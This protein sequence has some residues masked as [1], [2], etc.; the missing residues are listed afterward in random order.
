[1]GNAESISQNAVNMM[2]HVP[3]HR[4][5][6]TLEVDLIEEI[7]RIHG[8]DQLVGRGGYRVP[9]GAVRRPRDVAKERLRGWLSGCGFA[10]IV[11]SSFM[12]AG[13]HDRL[14]LPADD[15]RRRTLAVVN[16]RHGGDTQLRTVLA[17][18][19][20]VVARRNLNAGATPPLRFFQVNRAFRQDLPLGREARHADEA[21]LPAEPEY[22]QLVV[23]GW[24]EMG[25]GGVPADLL[26]L[27]G[28][29]E[30]LSAH[31]R[32]PLAIEPGA[33]EAWL[34][35]GAAWRI[36][37][38]A[39]RPVGAAGRVAPGVLAA[40]DVDAPVALAE[41]RLDDLD[42]TPAPARFEPFTRFPAVKRDLSLVV[43]ANVSFGQVQRTVTEAGGL[44]LESSEL[45][46]IY[47]GKGVP[48][49]QAA[50]G[51]RLKFRSP[52][53]SLKGETVDAAIGG[54][55]AALRDSWSIEPRG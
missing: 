15:P 30:A 19:A 20:L 26:E 17:P 2:I 8:L 50:F 53:G 6:L 4:R 39:G 16:P 32:V 49:G 35:A 29:V 28:A 13:D 27:R 45:F 38:G 52:K 11:T 1:M 23:A 14:G 22:L 12:E 51:I 40:F 3:S 47:R 9:G 5:D 7:A 42:L 31:L 41:I 54:I 43:P 44:L 25:L 37:N 55:L 21:L 10:E 18:S 24:R 34:E 33:D 46:D 36:L 48:E